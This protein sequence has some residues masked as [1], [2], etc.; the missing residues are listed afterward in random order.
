MRLYSKQCLN[1]VRNIF[2]YNSISAS[3]GDHRNSFYGRLQGFTDI[4]RFVAGLVGHIH[5]G[6]LL[7]GI[8]H[9]PAA[10]GTV[11]FL[12]SIHAVGD[13]FFHHLFHRR[14]QSYHDLYLSHAIHAGQQRLQTVF[15]LLCIASVSII[16]FRFRGFHRIASRVR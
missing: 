10:A 4:G 9:I 7:F 15:H 2:L 3:L 16:F 6:F 1:H 8:D 14:G 5:G 12:G 11:R 13:V